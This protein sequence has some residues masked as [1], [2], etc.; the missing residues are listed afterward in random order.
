[1]NVEERARKLRAA[2]EQ[3][4]RLYYV[5][6]APEIT[7]AEYDAL[8]RELQALEAEHP[9]LRS[10]D[11]PTQR[12]GGA[13]LVLA[14]V[15]RCGRPGPVGDVAGQ[16]EAGVP[17][18]IRQLVRGQLDVQQRTVPAL[19]PGPRDSRPLRRRTWRR[20]RRLGR[21][22]Q[23]HNGQLEHLIPFVTVALERGFVHI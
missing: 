7:D 23:V 2:I 16:H 10:A 1:M 4:N 9:E 20:R 17:P 18:L 14:R 12:V 22:E 19:M 8:F 21:R 11:S 15:Q 6:D 3:H 13:Q 5:E